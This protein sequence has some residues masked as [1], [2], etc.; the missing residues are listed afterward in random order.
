MALRWTSTAML[1][2][3]KGLRGLKAYK[4]LGIADGARSSPIPPQRR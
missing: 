1:A 4:Q 3:V 2:A